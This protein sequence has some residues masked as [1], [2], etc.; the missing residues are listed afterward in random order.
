MGPSLAPAA[1][2][3]H[4]ACSSGAVARNA[5][6]ALCAFYRPSMDPHSPAPSEWESSKATA[7]QSFILPDVAALH[8]VCMHTTVQS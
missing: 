6:S 1:A 8:H 4:T 3:V 5:G 2:L 7:L